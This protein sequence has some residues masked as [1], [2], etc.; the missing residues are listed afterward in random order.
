MPQ[1]KLKNKDL[2]GTPTYTDIMT[3]EFRGHTF[4]IHS[5]GYTVRVDD[6]QVF[7]LEMLETF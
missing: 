4:A 3:L 6:T 2:G 7:K 1:V 5:A